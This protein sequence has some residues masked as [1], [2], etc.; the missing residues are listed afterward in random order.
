MAS[1]NGRSFTNYRGINLSARNGALRFET[2]DS[3]PTTTT[4]E[5]LLYVTSANA[6]VFDSGVSTTTLGAAGAAV[7][8]ALN[9]SYD[10]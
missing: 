6:L 10:D 2:P 7:N 5:R 1:F 9:D 8:F 3:T 4:G